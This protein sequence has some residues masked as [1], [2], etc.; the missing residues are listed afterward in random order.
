MQAPRPLLNG[1]AK[2]FQV[3][4]N[5]RRSNAPINSSFLHVRSAVAGLNYK[6]SGVDIDA[7]AELV[8][9]IQKLNPSIGGFSGL[10]PFGEP[11]NH[12]QL[13][14]D[15]LQHVTAMVLESGEEFH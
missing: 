5:P 2:C 13:I 6:D 8:R 7:G 3:P 14:L 4:P 15:S 12:P 9:R 1:N 11:T 10:V